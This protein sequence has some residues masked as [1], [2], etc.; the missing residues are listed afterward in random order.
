MIHDLESR[1]DINVNEI[2]ML[3]F[4]NY[5]RDIKNAII[6]TFDKSF[7]SIMYDFL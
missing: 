3:L 1:V 7:R 4:I 6:V 5:V 2:N